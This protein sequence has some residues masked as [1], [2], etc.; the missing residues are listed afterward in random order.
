MRVN[1]QEDDIE[2][3]LR[4]K[5]KKDFASLEYEIQAIESLDISHK[6]H[7]TSRG[8]GEGGRLFDL[9]VSLIRCDYESIK[10][11]LDE[12]SISKF[13][14]LNGWLSDSVNSAQRVGRDVKSTYDRSIDRND[15]D[16]IRNERLEEV[17][18]L[19][20]SH[21]TD[22]EDLVALMNI[23]RFNK[24]IH[25]LVGKSAEVDT[26]VEQIRQRAGEQAARDAAD[27]FRALSEQHRDSS[28]AWFVTFIVFA[29]LF[30][31]AFAIIIATNPE[32]TDNLIAYFSKR[33]LGLSVPAMFMRIALSK[34]NAERNLSIIYKHRDTVLGQYKVF[35]QSL[36]EGEQRDQFRL[37]VSRFIFTDP[38]TG[39][40]AAPAGSE[41]NIGTVA[42]ALSK[43]AK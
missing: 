26:L 40:V 2:K 39:Y 30:V 33:A 35:D 17:K 18:R 28:F 29:A 14:W 24:D 38:S 21:R 4:D 20:T 11:Y 3:Q 34:Y 8:F 43:A 19:V 5:L 15:F 13:K 16:R 12:I 27:T 22:V 42:G 36:G 37:E 7:G 9:S 23:K 31:L 25:K 1:H 41:I 6:E 10:T 32:P